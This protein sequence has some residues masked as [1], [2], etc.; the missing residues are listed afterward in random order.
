MATLTKITKFRRNL[1]RKKAGR[2]RKA[3][4]RV[5]GTTPSFPIHTPEADANAPAAQLPGD[6]ESSE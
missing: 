1:R 2:A 4:I 3:A 6:G 5:N